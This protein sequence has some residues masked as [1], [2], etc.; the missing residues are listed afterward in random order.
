MPQFTNNKKPLNTNCC[1]SN[2][3][4][5]EQSCSCAIDMHQSHFKASW[6]PGG[7][8][9]KDI[10]VHKEHVGNVDPVS[11]LEFSC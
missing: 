1:F 11:V 8:V 2:A 7:L 3:K 6:S 5:V 9:D 4:E 10:S